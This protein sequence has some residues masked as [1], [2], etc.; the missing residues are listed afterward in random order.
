MLR[1]SSWSAEDSSSRANCA[2][3]IVCLHI[4]DHMRGHLGWAPGT[5]SPGNLPRFEVLCD[6]STVST[7]SCKDRYFYT[8]LQCKSGVYYRSS[9]NDFGGYILHSQNAILLKHFLLCYRSWSYCHEFLTCKYVTIHIEYYV[10]TNDRV[11]HHMQCAR[12]HDG[13]KI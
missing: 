4:S 10:R 1:Q 11:C 9:Q 7:S 13:Y 12:T 6:R 8:E 3:T 5:R 2:S